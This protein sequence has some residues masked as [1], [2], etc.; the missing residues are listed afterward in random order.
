MVVGLILVAFN[1]LGASKDTIEGTRER[2][3]EAVEGEVEGPLDTVRGEKRVA[4]R[5]KF[6]ANGQ[7][8]Q[9]VGR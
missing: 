7:A 1:V 2:V 3:D 6:I 8:P 5:S 9:E 4:I